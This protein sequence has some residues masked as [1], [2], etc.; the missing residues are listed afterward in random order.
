MKLLVQADDFGFTKGVTYGIV[1]A[2][3]NGVLRNTGLFT[4]MPSAE[5]A[6]SFMEDRPQACFGIDFNIVSGKPVANPKLIPALLDEK[7]EF[8]RSGV[9]LKDPRFQTEEGRRAMFP[10]DQVY[11]ELRAQY[12][13]FV[14]LT[15]KKPGYVHPHSLMHEN[16]MDAIRQIA[17]EEN[18]P[19]SMDIQKKFGFVS[20]HD[21]IPGGMSSMKKK[22]F[23]SQAQ[24][25]KNPLADVQKCAEEFLKH[26][27]VVISGHAGFVDADLLSHTTLSLERMRDHECVTSEWIK[28]WVKENNIELI[29]YRNLI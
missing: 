10:Y 18:V 12:D 16:Y 3:D 19:F 22:V 24:L 1:D 23:D 8:V 11:T 2:I 20:V 25:D 26:E 27:Y 4:N 14:Q 6:V 29:T 17:K 21:F 28:N 5:L 9:S 13:R 7:G 15:G